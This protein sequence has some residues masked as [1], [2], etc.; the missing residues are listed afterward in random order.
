VNRTDS[1]EYVAFN[2]T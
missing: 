2:I 1:E